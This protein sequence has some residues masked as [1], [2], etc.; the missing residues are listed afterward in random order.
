[1]SKYPIK[2]S[3]Q[4]FVA[5]KEFDVNAKPYIFTV[6]KKLKSTVCILK[7]KILKDLQPVQS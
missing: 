3:M 1:M 4:H 6:I 7:V 2:A 5:Y